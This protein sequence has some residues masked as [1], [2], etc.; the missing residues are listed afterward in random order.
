MD[1]RE[2]RN[3]LINISGW[4]GPMDSIGAANLKIIHEAADCIS[5]LQSR[6]TT[7]TK[8][9]EE[10]EK[11]LVDYAT[12]YCASGEATYPPED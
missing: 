8:A 2:V 11:R 12:M 7:E 9:K 5:S 1:A 3:H 10:A 6:L 4:F